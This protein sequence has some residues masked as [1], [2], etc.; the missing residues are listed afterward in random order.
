V[1]ALFI[2]GYAD[3]DLETNGAAVLHK[4]FEFPELGRQVRSLLDSGVA[5][6]RLKAG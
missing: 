4:P 6:N 3:D 2:S 5:G 1:K